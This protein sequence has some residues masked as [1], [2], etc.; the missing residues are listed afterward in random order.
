MVAAVRS[1]AAS[2]FDVLRNLAIF[3]MAALIGL[4]PSQAAPIPPPFV[5]PPNLAT[6]KRLCT[7]GDSITFNS[8]QITIAVSFTG[9]I[10]GNTLTVSAVTS[11]TLA[12]GQRIVG[13]SP[14]PTAAVAPTTVITALGTGSGLTGTYTVSVAQNVSSQTMAGGITSFAE[15]AGGYGTWTNIYSGY[16]IPRP[17]LSYDFGVSGNT[18]GQMLGRIGPVIAAQCDV[19]IMG[20]GTNDAVGSV[21]CATTVAN[22]YAMYSQLLPSSI[23]IKMSI[24]PRPGRPPSGSGFTLTQAQNAA[25]VNNADRKFAAT[26][27][28]KGFYFVDLNGVMTDPSQ[29]SVPQS[30]ATIASG[31]SGLTGSGTQTFTVTS[32]SCKVQPQFTGT[33]SGGVLTGSLTVIEAGSCDSS[34]TTTAN[35]SCACGNSATVTLAMMNWTVKVS[36]PTSI[37]HGAVSVASGG[38]ALT[39]GTQT[40]TLSGATCSTPVTFTGTVSGGVLS[41]PLTLTNAGLC[42]SPPQNPVSTTCTCG[43]TATVNATFRVDSFLSPVDQVHPSESGGSAIGTA[44]AAVID[45][46]VPPLPVLPKNPQNLFNLANNPQGNLLQNG[47]L[48]GPLTGTV[49]SGC[50]TSGGIPVNMAVQGNPLSGAACTA[51]TAVGSDGLNHILVT[52]SGIYTD[53]TGFAKVDIFGVSG[54][55]SSLNPGDILEGQATISVGTNAAIFSINPF[56]KT[57]ENGVNYTLNG[58]NGSSDQVVPTAG[59]GPVPIKTPQRSLVATPTN[60][61]LFVRVGFIAATAQPISAVIDLSAMTVNKVNWLYLPGV[62]DDRPAANDN[63]TPLRHVA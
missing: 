35:T 20:G 52:L 17:P 43:N 33:V 46:I 7:F 38:S 6:A 15:I 60:V 13:A 58:A 3:V 49:S 32:G 29:W 44:L 50:M 14:N 27:G 9:S 47:Y 1:K 51:E 53:E 21:P 59:F 5:P 28:N 37:A 61:S 55:T 10:A 25:C 63:D 23:V 42:T 36:S 62:W 40:F 57:I 12:V 24:F 22:N 34:I 39:D 18:T 11:G 54:F 26:A 31:G 16:R 45:Q 56:L 4:G 19:I 2:S 41:G 48:V 8:D 30:G